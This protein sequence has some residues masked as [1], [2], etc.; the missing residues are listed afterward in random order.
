MLPEI[1]FHPL[2]A[3][4]LPLLLKWLNEPHVWKWW[5]EGK[6]WTAEEVER[7]YASYLQQYKMDHG[8]KKSIYPFIIYYE[9]KPVGY[10]Q[11]YDA[12]DF[13]RSGFEVAD[14]WGEASMSVA[15]LD[16]YIGEPSCLGKGIGAAALSQFLK[17]HVYP[18]FSACLVDP[19]RHNTGAIQTYRKAGF[20]S[21]RDV[22]AS[23]VMVALA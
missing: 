6:R 7:K 1:E 14:V 3:L 17:T 19:D 2:A 21:Y 13:S 22:G 8:I 9:Q 11:Y 12:F 5:G 23:V 15:A 10:I 4:H 20:Q 16:F 18:W